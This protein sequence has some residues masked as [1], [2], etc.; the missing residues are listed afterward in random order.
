[1][2]SPCICPRTGP[3]FVQKLPEVGD[4]QA[5]RFSIINPHQGGLT[6]EDWAAMTPWQREDFIQRM[7]AFLRQRREARERELRKQEW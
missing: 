3:F 4:L 5:Q 2:C 6:Y 1:M 7:N